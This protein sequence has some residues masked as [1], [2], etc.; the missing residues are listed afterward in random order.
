MRSFSLCVS[1]ID[2]L[3]GVRFLPRSLFL[4]SRW[5]TLGIAVDWQSISSTPEP[6]VWAIGVMRSP[7]IQYHSPAGSIVEYFPYFLTQ[8]SDGPTAVRIFL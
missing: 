1:I 3:P 5:P 4:H 2:C 7:A 6:A 8:W